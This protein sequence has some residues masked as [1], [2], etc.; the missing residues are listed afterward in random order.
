MNTCIHSGVLAVWSAKAGASKVLAVE[1][2][3]M[4]KHARTIVQRN[5]V[6]DTVE[7]GRCVGGE[8]ARLTEC[9]CSIDW[10]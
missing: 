3:D 8:T 7:V 1:Y 10:T 6:A 4:A 2:T 5:G 9:V